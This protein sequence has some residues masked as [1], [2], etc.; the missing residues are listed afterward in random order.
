MDFGE[1]LLG[2]EI[3]KID[4]DFISVIEEIS[5]ETG[6]VPV[7]KEVR[8]RWMAKAA[9][10]ER[11]SESAWRKCRDRNGFAWLPAGGRGSNA[12]SK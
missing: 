10:G 9:G 2:L 7:Q 1:R 6:A 11:G 3:D 4:Q 5:K 8:K 12:H